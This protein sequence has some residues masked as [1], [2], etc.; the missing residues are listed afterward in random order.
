M[1]DGGIVQQPCILLRELQTELHSRKP[2]SIPLDVSGDNPYCNYVLMSDTVLS[3]DAHVWAMNVI[4]EHVG[5]FS[6]RGVEQGFLLT[7]LLKCE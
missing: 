1:E 2:C 7:I 3:G 4:S 6:S 5:G